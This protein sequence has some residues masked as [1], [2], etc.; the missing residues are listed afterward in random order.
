MKLYDYDFNN[1]IDLNDLVKISEKLFCYI[2]TTKNKETLIISLFYLY[3]NYSQLTI[4][5]FTV[6]I[7]ELYH[8]RL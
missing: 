8:F 4:R 7:F 2:S 6:K 1:E 3:N 5:Y